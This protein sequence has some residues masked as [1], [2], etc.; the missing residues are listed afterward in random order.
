MPL[1][2]AIQRMKRWAVFLGCS[3]TIIWTLEYNESC[4]KISKW[5]QTTQPHLSS[6]TDGCVS[7]W[8]QLANITCSHNS[9]A[10]CNTRRSLIYVNTHVPVLVTIFPAKPIFWGQKD[11]LPIKD[12]FTCLSAGLRLGTLWGNVLVNISKALTRMRLVFPSQSISVLTDILQP[13]HWSAGSNSAMRTNR[14]RGRKCVSSFDSGHATRR[15]RS[16]FSLH[17]KLH[18][19]VQNSIPGMIV[20]QLIRT[21]HWWRAQFR[22]VWTFVKILARP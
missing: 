12:P 17:L 3:H 2:K 6:T 18:A 5:L 13:T 22:N 9:K 19:C 7:T 20:A 14:G 15:P 8:W 11:R 16:W 10:G 4:L 21:F 1:P